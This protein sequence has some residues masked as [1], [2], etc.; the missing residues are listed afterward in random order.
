M[1]PENLEDIP[2]CFIVSTGR[3]GS[4][5]L[6]TMLNAHPD[7]LSISEQPFTLDLIDGYSKKKIW[8]ESDLENYISDFKLFASTKISTQFSSYKQLREN[9]FLHNQNINFNNIIK[10]SLLS[11]FPSKQKSS[12][13][14]I[15]AKEL[16]FHTQIK[17]ISATYPNAKFILLTRDPRDNVLIK[18]NR[19][20]RRNETYN[21]FRFIYAWRVVYSKLYFDLIKYAQNRFKILKYEDLINQPESTLKDICNFLSISFNEEMMNYKTKNITEFENKK[22]TMPEEL[23]T[24]LLRDH[25]GL[26]QNIN[27]EKI[28]IW[29]K[30]LHL[31]TSKQIWN[32]CK[33]PAQIFGYKADFPDDFQNEKL[34][35]TYKI[36]KVQYYLYNILR[37]QI[38]FKTPFWLRRCYRKLKYKFVQTE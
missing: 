35:V 34:G 25:Q 32:E 22:E 33:E 14:L 5:L 2:L 18:I 30:Q 12:I 28:G 24:H 4:T 17:K 15:I 1:L 26:L 19:A 21:I 3:T 23:V 10:L 36:F 16:I 37:P 8:K 7:V 38:Y 11:F 20:K 13:K 6:S 9:I 31:T 29:K 27:P